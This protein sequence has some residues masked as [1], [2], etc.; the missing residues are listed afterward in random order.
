MT[1]V[2]QPG[3]FSAAAEACHVSQPSL[4]AQIAKLEDELD[5]RL[6]QRGRHGARLTQ[7]GELFRPRAAD[8][9]AQPETGPRE[10]AEP[11]GLR[12]GTVAL[13][14]LPT[15][16]AYLG[17]IAT[18]DHPEMVGVNTEVAHEHMAGLNMTHAVAQAWSVVLRGFAEHVT[19]AN[20]VTRL[21]QLPLQAWD[22]NPKP[23][24]VRITTH[25]VSGREIV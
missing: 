5:G 7:R 9:L 13:G 24:F 23:D 14:C 8:A 18:L 15:T 17:L 2:G 10:L 19:D 1:A 16:G 22:P 20:E 4:S 12:R 11:A 6:L 21:E 25:L 3:V